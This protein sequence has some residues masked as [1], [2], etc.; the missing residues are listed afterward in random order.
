[1]E[2]LIGIGGRNA[3][4]NLL[5]Q[6]IHRFKGLILIAIIIGI[7]T[8]LKKIHTEPTKKQGGGASH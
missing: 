5:G 6:F 3:L 7:I 1:L 4:Y 8:S 2:Q